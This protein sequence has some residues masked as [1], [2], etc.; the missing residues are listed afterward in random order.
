MLE[1]GE[2]APD[3]ELL[4]N[5]GERWCLSEQHGKVV[6]LLFYPCDETLVCT[7]QLCSLMDHWNDYVATKAE[8]VGVSTGS[9][10]EHNSF[11][12]KHRLPI[13]VLADADSRVTEAYCSHW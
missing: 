7:R 13:P 1:E 5:S 12:Q 6:A 4:S 11:V 10:G 3:F 2:P 9:P 8:V